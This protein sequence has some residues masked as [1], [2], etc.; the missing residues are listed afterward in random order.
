MAKI[1]LIPDLTD[2]KKIENLTKEI[3]KLIELTQ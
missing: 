1:D 3:N 2:P